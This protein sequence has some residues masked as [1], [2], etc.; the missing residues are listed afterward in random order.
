MN[1]PPSL[2]ECNKDLTCES[3]REE[4]ENEGKNFRTMRHHNT[5]RTKLY[6]ACNLP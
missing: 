5:R 1:C 2:L 6:Q 4:R 3:G